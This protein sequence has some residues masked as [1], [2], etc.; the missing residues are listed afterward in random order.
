MIWSYLDLY[1]VILRYYDTI[2]SHIEWW[3]S[4]LDGIEAIMEWDTTKWDKICQYWTDMTPNEWY[5]ASIDPKRGKKGWNRDKWREYCSNWVILG[6]IGAKWV[7]HAKI[8]EMVSR[9]ERWCQ[10]A[11]RCQYRLHLVNIESNWMIMGWILL[12]M[13]EYCA[14]WVIIGP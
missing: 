9:L 7:I 2:W 13:G 3:C 6:T 1:R 10:D 4:Q 8:G 12:Q 14:I 5:L 11:S